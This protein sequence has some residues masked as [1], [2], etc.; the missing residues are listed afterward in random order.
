MIEIIKKF[1]ILIEKYSTNDIAIVLSFGIFFFIIGLVVLNYNWINP[2]EGAH[3]ADG[4]LL[5]QGKIPL[6]DY[7]SRQPFY[8]ILVALFMKIFGISLFG[9]RV[10]PLLSSIGIG[11]LLYQI[12]K[13]LFNREVALTSFLIYLFL[14]FTILFAP[15]VKMHNIVIFWTGLGL[16]LYIKFLKNER[17]GYLILSG[18]IMGFS[19]YI[20]ETSWAVSLTIMLTIFF[21][22]S[23]DFSKAIKK[24]VIFLGSFLSVAGVVFL[25]Y[26]HFKGFNEIWY[27]SLNP[28]YIFLQAMGKLTAQ[29]FPADPSPIA[30]TVRIPGQ[31]VSRSLVEVKRAFIMSLYLIAWSNKDSHEKSSSVGFFIMPIWFVLILVIYSFY[32]FMRGFFPQYATELYPPLIICLSYVTSAKLIQKKEKILWH[33]VILIIFAYSVFAVHKV[34][35]KIFPDLLYQIYPDLGTYFLIS[36]ISIFLYWL[37]RDNVYKKNK[38]AFIALLA[39]FLFG[40]LMR[41]NLLAMHELKKIIV[42]IILV[43]A[44]LIIYISAKKGFISEN[45]VFKKYVAIPL[46]IASIIYSFSVA[47]VFL[48]PSYNN[49]W[50][51]AVL[52][53]VDNYL[54]M[55]ANEGDTLLSGAMVW[56]IRHRVKPFLNITHPLAFLSNQNLEVKAS[57]E[58]ELVKKPPTFIILDGYTESCYNFVE[59]LLN[60]KINNFLKKEL[61]IKG[62]IYTVQIYKLSD[63]E[64][65]PN[66][67]GAFHNNL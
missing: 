61:E 10:F 57:I 33:L 34:A 58:N 60:E 36:I 29:I 27:S 53:K 40:A 37:V 50:E 67:Q 26:L 25:F 46:L 52:K 4:K 17:I 38:T 48:G 62:F 19:Y 6:V 32:C 9:G 15:I 23:N 1:R 39:A 14:P 55:N 66:D 21:I 42:V 49:V 44:Y 63:S 12:S 7:T 20:R 13:N 16:L 45:Q 3:L 5:L 18:I 51:P 59:S 65:D 24:F 54:K 30:E 47:F 31:Q 2:D 22:N 56:T 8:V 11:V 35:L 64:L 41:F 28:F 43:L